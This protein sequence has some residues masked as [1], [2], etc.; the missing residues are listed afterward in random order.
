MV[1]PA[2]RVQAEVRKVAEVAVSP[3]RNSVPDAIDSFFASRASETLKIEEFPL[4]VAQILM[5]GEGC[6]L[7]E[8]SFII[9]VAG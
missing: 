8:T 9:I 1:S 4:G 5:G 3:H 7:V 6:K 2:I